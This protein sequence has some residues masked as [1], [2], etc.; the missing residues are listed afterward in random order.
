[1]YVVQETDTVFFC[2]FS[3]WCFP[4]LFA[5]LLF[6]VVTIASWFV[7]SFVAASL[8]TSSSLIFAFICDSDV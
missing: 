4:A 6:E 5:F 3:L 2:L 1:M 8:M 7:W